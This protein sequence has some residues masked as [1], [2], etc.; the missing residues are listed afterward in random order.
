MKIVIKIMILLVVISSLNACYTDSEEELYQYYIG[1]CEVDTASFKKDVKPIIDA[2]CNYC[3]GTENYM[4]SGNGI[5]LG[6]YEK[7][8]AF[9]QLRPNVFLNSLQHN[10]GVSPMPKGDKKLD[11]C[12]L[13]K[14]EVWVNDTMPNN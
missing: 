3:H 13:N 12:I 5:N 9:E 2:K 6:S 4:V 11:I 7:I 10:S 1:D 14:I 8:K